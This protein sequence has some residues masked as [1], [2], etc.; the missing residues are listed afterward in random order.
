MSWESA[1]DLKRRHPKTR[2]MFNHLYSGTIEDAATDLQV[3]EV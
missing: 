1:A 2:F 3:I